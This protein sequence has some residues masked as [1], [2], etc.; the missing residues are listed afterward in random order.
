MFFRT[1]HDATVILYRRPDA[2]AMRFFTATSLELEAVDRA[3]GEIMPEEH[4]PEKR[5]LCF[6]N[7]DITKLLHKVCSD[8]WLSISQ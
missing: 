1:P 6:I 2:R 7:E 5:Q 8:I 3:K 4:I